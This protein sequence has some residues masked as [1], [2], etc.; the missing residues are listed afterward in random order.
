MNNQIS[1]N[2]SNHKNGTQASQQ[3]FTVNPSS[4]DDMVLEPITL[5]SLFTTPQM[6]LSSQE[7]GRPNLFLPAPHPR[8]PLHE[9]IDEA[10]RVIDGIDS[11]MDGFDL[12]GSPMPNGGGNRT[13]QQQ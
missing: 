13:T 6:L 8:R 7:Q 10:L 11:G 3:R 1:T 4:A 9:I 5:A 2:T 12:F